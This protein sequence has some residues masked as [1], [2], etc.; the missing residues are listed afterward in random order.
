MQL[1]APDAVAEER[2]LATSPQ[3]KIALRQFFTSIQR[4]VAEGRP[5]PALRDCGFRVFSQDDEDGLI[6]Y[7]LAVVGIGTRQFVDI[8]AGNCVTASNCA[9]L[10]LTL[11]FHG[12]FVDADPQRIDEGRAFYAS[13]ADT[14]P[15]PPKTVCS[16]ATRENVNDLI[17]GAGIDGPID[18][19]SIDIDGNDHWIWRGVDVVQ[20]S[21]VVIETHT[22]YGLDDIESPYRP[23]FDWRKLDAG[24][25]LGAS[26]VAMS[27]VG[28]ELGYRL[29]GC[30]RYGFNA[31]FLR[32]G[33]AE[34]IVPTVDPDALLQHAWSREAQ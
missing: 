1:A 32:N 3:T 6:L 21:I 4:A 16:F 33:L 7:L 19:L 5:L 31:I 20:P 30:N 9:N 17:R 23:D 13:H 8:G 18:V 15:Y 10:A 25:P 14:A 22:E 29:V 26:A 24:A 12:V 34:G 28:S 11:G 2:R 27:R